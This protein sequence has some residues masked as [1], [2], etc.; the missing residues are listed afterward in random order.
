VQAE[1]AESEAWQGGVASILPYR[2]TEADEIREA[3]QEE[4][5]SEFGVASIVPFD[6]DA[7]ADGSSGELDVLTSED[8]EA[9]ASSAAQKESEWAKRSRVRRYRLRRWLLQKKLS[10]AVI[11]SQ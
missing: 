2:S 10:E 3:A 5:D 11:Y 1:A 4:E 9:A 8:A 7:A 6:S